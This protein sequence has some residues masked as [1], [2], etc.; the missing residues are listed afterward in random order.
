MTYVQNQKTHRRRDF[1]SEYIKLLE[2]HGIEYD[3]RYIW[4]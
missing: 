3:E 1:K 4:R 2:C